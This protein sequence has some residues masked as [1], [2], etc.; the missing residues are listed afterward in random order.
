[1][2][3]KPSL[4]TIKANQA[5]EV[6]VCGYNACRAIFAQRPT[7]I[8]RVY[9][10][11]KTLPDFGDIL[12][13]C[14]KNRKAYHVVSEQDLE[15]VAATKHHDGVC[16][17][18][19]RQSK[20]SSEN[21][22][23]RLRSDKKIDCI[24]FLDGVQNPHNCGAILRVCS[25]FGAS[26]VV[27]DDK[28][29]PKLSAAAY[30]TAQGGAEDVE[31]IGVKDPMATIKDLKGFGYKIIATSDQAKASV[32]KQKLP[33]KVVFIFGSESS[34]VSPKYIDAADANL[35]IPHTGQVKSLN[36]ASAA[37]IFI[38]EHWRQNH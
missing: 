7:D 15:K 34:G 36:V 32:F 28:K 24:V 5:Q 14:A 2:K 26:T 12:K 21:L 27:V 33:A 18:A 37:S 19:K 4:A 20:G 29:T 10:T 22:V 35:L 16:I 11:E 38:A 25:H 6:K 9:V 8:V 31:L 13:W 23:A 17:L 3:Q 1:M 30:R